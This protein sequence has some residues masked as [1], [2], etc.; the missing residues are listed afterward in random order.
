MATEASARPAGARADTSVARRDGRR[1]VT[2]TKQATKTTEFFAWLAV[3]AGVLIAGLVTKA[4]DGN[5][6]RLLAQDAWLYASILT[7]AYLISR[8]LA[9]SGSYEPYYNDGTNAHDDR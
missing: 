8:G 3:T 7:A 1:L 2:E 5:D 9:K 6:D 4:G